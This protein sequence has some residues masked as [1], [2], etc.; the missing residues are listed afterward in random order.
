MMRMRGLQAMQ[1][2]IRN[3][4]RAAVGRQLKRPAQAT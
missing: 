2:Y 3:R 1:F 4:I